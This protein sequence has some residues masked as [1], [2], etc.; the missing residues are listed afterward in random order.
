MA[1]RSPAFLQ[2]VRIHHSSSSLGIPAVLCLRKPLL[3]PQQNCGSAAS[4]QRS[5]PAAKANRENGEVTGSLLTDGQGLTA[6]SL[7]PQ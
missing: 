3:Q 6:Q 1:V 7:I 5:L 4:T 2:G